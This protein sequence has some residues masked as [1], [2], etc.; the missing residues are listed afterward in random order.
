MNSPRIVKN[1]PAGTYYIGDPCYVFNADSWAKIIEINDC[2]DIPH[3]EFKDK[4]VIAFGTKSG[5]GVY[6]GFCVDSGLIGIVD[7]SL[8]EE[9]SA[10][11][12]D[13]FDRQKHT[14]TF[15]KPFD[16]EWNNGDFYIGNQITIYTSDDE[17][18]DYDDYELYDED[19][20]EYD[21][22]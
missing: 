7:I 2:F 5:D 4:P 11:F 22:E 13:S 12:N 17:D 19:D 9:G 21:G 1:I 16:F 14:I 6:N 3:I 10:F 15:D 18:E 20:Y 8:I